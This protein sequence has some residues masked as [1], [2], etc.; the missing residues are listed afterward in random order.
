MDTTHP[1]VEDE[2]RLVLLRDLAHQLPPATQLRL[3]VG[4]MNELV[5]DP[6]VFQMIESTTELAL[7]R[8]NQ[9]PVEG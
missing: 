3:L 8:H 6:T 7:L 2:L 1:S 5:S 9:M 4:Y